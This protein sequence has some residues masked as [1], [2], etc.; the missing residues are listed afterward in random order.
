MPE[1][2]KTLLNAK[3]DAAT[4]QST[5]TYLS[6]VNREPSPEGLR[7]AVVG[8]V[9]KVAKNAKAPRA[10][11]RDARNESYGRFAGTAGSICFDARELHHLGP[12]LGFVGEKFT[13]VG[14]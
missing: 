3:E 12:L 13:E 1:K 9:G 4:R 11:L 7:G 5:G 10:I 14:G 8:E 2:W 6:R